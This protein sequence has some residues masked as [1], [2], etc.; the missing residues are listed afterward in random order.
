MPAPAIQLYFHMSHSP[1]AISR[2]ALSTNQTPPA[3]SCH[4]EVRSRSQ[5][6]SKPTPSLPFI[7]GPATLL[8]TNHL[9]GRSG[10]CAASQINAS[11]PFTPLT[12]TAYRVGQALRSAAVSVVRISFPPYTA[13]TSPCFSAR[14][15]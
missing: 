9:N 1:S 12:L 15:S 10:V 14:R 3:P 6:T 8:S 13:A 5:F 2:F 7:N 11:K 4:A